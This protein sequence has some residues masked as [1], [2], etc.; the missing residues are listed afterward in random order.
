MNRI[1][2]LVG[3]LWTTTLVAAEPAPEFRWR[4]DVE[5]PPITETALVAV[6]LDSH[7]FAHTRDGWPD[8]RLQTA[9][10]TAT[11]FVVRPSTIEKTRTIRDF[12]V[13]DQMAAKIDDE[14]GLQ[15][16]LRLR[17]KEPPPDG[18]RIVSPLR[19]FEHQVRVES[20]ADEQTWQPAGEPTLI[21]DYTRFVDARNDVVP[22]KAG[23]HRHFRLT[24]ADVTAEQESQL[25]ELHRNLQGGAETDRTERTTIARRPF[26]IDRIEFYRDESHP[27]STEPR[28]RDYPVQNLT[29]TQ[30]EDGQRTVVAFEM[31]R[32][33]VTALTAVT[34]AQNFS[35]TVTVGTEIDSDASGPLW[36]PLTSGTLTR[37]SVGDLHRD[38]LTIAIPETR[39][40]RLRLVVENDDSPP[41][42][43]TRITASGPVY[44]LLFLAERDQKYALSYGS[45]EA[46]AGHYDTAALQASLEH[47]HA[48][49]PAALAR[50]RENPNAPADNGRRWAVWNDPRVLIAIIVGMTLVLGYV[51]YVVARDVKRGD[52]SH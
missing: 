48:A 31:Q 24:I 14:Q 51:L 27:Q 17:E 45:P 44:E 19:D 29:T 1:L 28:T 13:A 39:R 7:V 50:P 42:V 46:E 2:V 8:V 34:A 40:S 20:S 4:R 25:L 21:F 43:I 6:P 52:D 3:L 9:D 35:R 26:R 37:F 11:A 41:I 15:I 22:V 10:G 30:D 18:L 36:Q 32:E 38:E 23:D 5:L 12:W 47:N 33:P 49:I 16:L